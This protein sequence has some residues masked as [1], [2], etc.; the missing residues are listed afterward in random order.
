MMMS[1]G[2][3][4]VLSISGPKMAQATDAA[5]ILFH[6]IDE[7]PYVDPNDDGESVTAKHFNGD[8]EFKDVCF[9]YPTRPDLKVLT[10]FNV[11]IESGKTTAL[12]GPSGSGKSTVI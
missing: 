5:T 8:I 1:S 12:V 6:I 3:Q 10:N 2:P 9:N 7:K 11:T 4:T